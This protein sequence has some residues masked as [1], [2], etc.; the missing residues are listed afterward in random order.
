[1]AEYFVGIFLL[2]AFVG[3]LFTACGVVVGRL[4]WRGKMKS[5]VEMVTVGNNVKSDM[6]AVKKAW[7]ETEKYLATIEEQ[8][9]T[10][11]L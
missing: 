9:R 1:M 7:V 11:Q 2:I 6:L 8:S 3:T 4:I 10:P 5:I